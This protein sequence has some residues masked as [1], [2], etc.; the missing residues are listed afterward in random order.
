MQISQNWK[1]IKKVIKPKGKTQWKRFIHQ[2]NT[3]I[4]DILFLFGLA[5]NSVSYGRL[6]LDKSMKCRKT[7][8][9]PRWTQ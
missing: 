3:K 4:P 1:V 8:D 2:Q 9:I 7:F 5:Y 6:F